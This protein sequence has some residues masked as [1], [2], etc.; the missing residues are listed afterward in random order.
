MTSALV[1]SSSRAS[2]T[3]C[4]PRRP[5]HR[6]SSGI[7]TTKRYAQ[8]ILSRFAIF[9]FSFSSRFPANRRTDGANFLSLF[10]SL[11]SIH[12]RISITPRAEN[13]TTTP[14][15]SAAPKLV[16]SNAASIKVHERIRLEKFC[17]FCF[18]R[19]KSFFF[20]VPLSLG[21]D[22]VSLSFLL[23]RYT[24]VGREKSDERRDFL[25]RQHKRFFVRTLLCFSAKREGK[26]YSEKLLL[27]VSLA[28]LIKKI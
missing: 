19:S 11:I 5:F 21:G 25:C 6:K 20:F 13:E 22:R 27:T 17:F 28:A 4:S 18:S 1:S 2:T 7:K 9:S 3:A 23:S 12:R 15:A 8:K 16:P 14:A 24:T 10:Y 26:Y